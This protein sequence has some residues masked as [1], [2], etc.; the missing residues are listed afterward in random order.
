MIYISLRE[1]RIFKPNGNESLQQ[2]FLLL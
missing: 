2:Q 1:A